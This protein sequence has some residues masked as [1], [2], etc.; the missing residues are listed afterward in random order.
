MRIYGGDGWYAVVGIAKDVRWSSLADDAPPA[1]YFPLLQGNAWRFR[2][3]TL[4]VRTDP[5]ARVSLQNIRAEAAVIAGGADAIYDVQSMDAMIARS[6]QQWRFQAML[7]GMF[8]ALALIIAVVGIFGV[9]SYAVVQRTREIGVRLALGAQRSDMLRLILGG[10][11]RPVLAGLV[12]GWF[13]AVL[14]T[15]TLASFL[16]HITPTDVPTYG[17]TAALF[18]VVAL[19][20]STIPAYRATQVDPV[21]TLR[22]D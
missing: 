4:L 3:L 16:F 8:G 14:A 18:L 22:Q 17:V 13:S 21:V 6:I 15:R 9:T 5:A 20:A 19:L 10:T 7:L 1:V 12:A 11:A 2:G